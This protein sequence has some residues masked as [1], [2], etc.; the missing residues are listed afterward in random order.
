M[1]RKKKKL[2]NTHTPSRGYTHTYTHIQKR[3]EEENSGE[4]EESEGD[5]REIES[6]RE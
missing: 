1:N 5:L 2:H 6:S 3:I 4:G